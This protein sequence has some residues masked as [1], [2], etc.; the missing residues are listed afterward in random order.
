MPSYS[1]GRPNT[2]QSPCPCCEERESQV[3]S[4][5]DGKSRGELIT[6]SCNRCG[7]GRIDPMP[8][9]AE[10][11][12]WY[13]ASYREDYKGATTPSL[14]HVLRAGR[15]SIDRYEWIR[16][17]YAKLPRPDTNSR[18]ASLDIGA[19]SGEFV[20]LMSRRG[21]EARG[22]EPHHGYARYAKEHLGLE[23]RA[24][25]V[26]QEI[27]NIAPHSVDLIS[28]FHVLE[29]LASPARVL[30]AL[31]HRLTSNGV[32]YIEVPNAAR[33]TSPTYMF[34]R[35]HVLYF[36]HASLAQL[37]GVA[38]FTIV[39]RNDDHDDN[40]RVVAMYT[41]HHQTPPLGA[42][43]HPLVE[44]QKARTWASYLIRQALTG[45]P[46]T[47]MRTRAEERRWASR[48]LNGKALLE[49]L[50]SGLEATNSQADGH[51]R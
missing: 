15:N 32:L 21:Y 6:L 45:R 19:S 8:S 34:F 13:K 17:A 50:H 4:T 2:A 48:F 47:K 28:M 25:A 35:A 22:I 33:P 31:G 7:L 38:G 20:F 9:E 14:R 12:A 23:V 36:T 49:D 11:E 43:G 5:R 26:G 37:L 44:A 29:H 41:G 51:T 24:G 40:L 39:A 30:E 42:H 18:A 1:T 10:L 3:I 27:L 46:L 16:Q